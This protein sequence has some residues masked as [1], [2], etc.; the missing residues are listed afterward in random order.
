M[1]DRLINYLKYSGASVTITM[2]PYHWMW[3]PFFRFGKSEEAWDTAPT[4]RIC[5]LFL[6]ARIW[7]DDG[8][9]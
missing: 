2:N 8:R 7:I 3:I 4:T 5:F 6:T 1:V 9:W